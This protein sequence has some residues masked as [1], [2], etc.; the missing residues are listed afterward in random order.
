VE[1]KLTAI[2]CADV[3]GYSRLMGEDEEATLR[4]LS[5]YRKIVDSL[6]EQHRGRFVNS[7]GDSVLA[8]FA[9]VVN[10][11]QCAV[12]IQT[13]L[14]AENAT[15]P[16]ERRMEFRIG[17]NL[18][19]VMVDGEQ[20]YG[21][22]VNVAARLESL[23]EPGS[24]CIS[25]TVHAQIKNKLALSYEDLGAQ[26]VKNIAEPVRVLRVMLRPDN[27]L[28]STSQLGLTRRLDSMPKRNDII[29]GHDLGDTSK[30]GSTNRG[31]SKGVFRKEGE[32]WT[33]AYGDKL[34]HLR[35]SKGLSYIVYLLRN[36]GTEFHALDLIGGIVNP[37]G[38]SESESAS[39]A[40]GRAWRETLE[41]QAGGLGDAGA[42]LDAQSKAEYRRRLVELR[43]EL[44]QAKQRGDIERAETAEDEI[45]ALKRELS[46]AV[47]LGGRER[48]AAS[49]S[50]RARL[51][52]TRAIKSALEKIFGNDA[53]LGEM[54]TRTIKTGT[55]C[56]YN[57]GS[58]Y[59][60]EWE[61]G[62][63]SAGIAAVGSGISASELIDRRSLVRGAGR[64]EETPLL[65]LSFAE[66]TAFVGREAERA[67]I[68]AAVEEA[69]AGSGA[70]V[71]LA[72]GAGV[73]KTRLAIESA[74]EASK[75]GA[76]VLLGRC[77]E[78]EE[79]HPYLPFVEMLEMAL[80]QAPSKEGFRRA[81]GENAAELAQLAP[82]L[83]QAFGDIPQPLEL[84][85]QQARRY[86][87]DSICEFLARSARI[88]PIFLVLDDLHWADE[89]TLSLLVHLSLRISGMPVVI[90]GTYRDTGPDLN[91]ALVKALDQ[92][93]RGRVRPIR[94]KGL[95][96][97]AVAR[98]LQ[99][100]CGR[101]P[102]PHL[103]DA[104]YQETEGNPFFIEELFKHLVE[105]GK[106]LD[107]SGQFRG[108]LRVSELDVPENVRLVIGR[109]L[110]RLIEASQQ[111][112][113]A[114]AVIGRSFSFKLLE[115]L[116]QFDS[117][118]L[119]EA[120]EEALG[121]GLIVSSAE[122]P[123][124]P[125]NFAHELVRQTLL[126][127]LSPPRRQR[128]HQRVA[129]AIEKTY[130]SDLDSHAA[131]IA[132]HLIQAGADA[133]RATIM[134]YL[135]VAG[136]RAMQAAAYE[137]A[138]HHFEAALARC[139]ATD[140]RGRAELLSELGMTKRSLDRWEEALA[141]WRD[142]L[143]AY[144]ALGDRGAAGRLSVAI[145]EAFNWA[146]RYFDGAPIAYRALGQLED[147]A[148]AERAWLLGVL[149]GIHTVAG[150]HQL[151]RDAIVEAARL[152]EELGE[153]KILGEVI[154]Y[155]SF[156]YFAFARLDDAIADGLRAAD[157]LRAGS[158]HWSLAQTL[159]WLQTAAFEAGQ[160]D[161]VRAIGAELEPLAIKL[162]H[163]A[164]R[165][166]SVRIQTW[167]EFSTHHDLAR[168][169]ESFE[170][171]LEI[172][173]AAKLP[174][175]ATCYARLSAVNFVR[176]KWD[177]ALAYA[178]QACAAELLTA[179][180]GPG[181][182][183]LFRQRAYLGDRSGALE[184]LE[185]KRPRMPR[186]DS[187]PNRHGAWALM[188]LA[189][190]GLFVLGERA[191]AGGLYP[192]AL[193]ATQTG[194]Q[195][196]PEIARFPQT[197]AG[198]SAAAACQWDR[199]EEH[200]QIATRQA[201]QFQHQLEQAEILRFHGQMLLERGRSADLERAHV[202]LTSATERYRKFG[203]SRHAEL[204]RSLLNNWTRSHAPLREPDTNA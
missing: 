152:A 74:R 88:R 22:G 84:P 71:M 113:A 150:D 160:L 158:V 55:F 164:A 34:V 190:E 61:F 159:A 44:E 15:L 195:F 154:S 68:G 103:V 49:A 143:D 166:L 66:Q 16:A 12:E 181:A 136:K 72:G 123:E 35:D 53:T 137:D 192:L 108:D 63:P 173:R 146:G 107:A 70:L 112:L 64:D 183:M 102:P 105:E 99:S 104:I 189:I 115:S 17:I 201:Q 58:R 144:T 94:L 139:E 187:S 134:H 198:I 5:S 197:A 120:I 127:G 114:A 2:L 132:H 26:T 177:A 33:L 69:L 56:F 46:R 75:K 9:S 62:A 118:P 6:I 20:I 196:V 4:T 111:A 3:Y 77:V 1:R 65:A 83:R 202:L 167:C 11:V 14:K 117:D 40:P 38:D 168:L 151:A 119:L 179:F 57:P 101:E 90:V 80:G 153:R 86:L 182:G 138:L 91:R 176:G 130:A 175:V 85:P 36:P 148:K 184:L 28:T 203:M 45:D 191:E 193:Q 73:G 93:V 30:V 200:F 41:L 141:H 100:L 131:E 161:R 81:L 52:V 27:S 97:N 165:M 79:P 42:M 155:R 24:I 95:P 172:T 122:G 48:R 128:L 156:Y 149:S 157:L 194:I 25:D 7:A 199:A 147:S 47:G 145:V 188:L 29:S 109:R 37:V 87:F 110:D 116:G 106:V 170:R 8:E 180:D 162:G 31:I 19:D 13:T 133:D 10:A 204:T 186:S 78:T 163:S 67:Q 121:M 92:L 18:S 142:S 129:N 125:F 60:V 135:T 82:R 140:S 32:F 43:E 178:E 96:P 21:D 89:S 50:E 54:L 76:L 51:S 126:A 124:A 185:Q 174:W 59:P 169:E 98:I 39:K 171:D 23:A